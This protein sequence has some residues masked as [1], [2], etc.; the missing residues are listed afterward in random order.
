MRRHN[1]EEAARPSLRYHTPGCEQL[2]VPIPFAFVTQGMCGEIMAERQ[3]VL[4]LVPPQLQKQQM[5]LLNKYDPTVSADA[6][7]ALLRLFSVKSPD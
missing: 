7:Y 1:P 5:K 3:Q 2:F 4:G 6:F